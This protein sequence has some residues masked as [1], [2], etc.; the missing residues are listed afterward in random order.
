MGNL[1]SITGQNMALKYEPGVSDLVTRSLWL[2]ANLFCSE[3]PFNNNFIGTNP[4]CFIGTKNESA[5]ISFHDA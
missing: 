5:K 1:T 3:E 4:K 2:C